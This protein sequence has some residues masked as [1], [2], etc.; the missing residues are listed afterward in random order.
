MASQIPA[1]RLLFSS[2]S[3]LKLTT[4]KA[5]DPSLLGIWVGSPPLNVTYF[6]TKCNKVESVSKLGR[7]RHLICQVT[8]FFIHIKRQKLRKNA[9]TWIYY[10]LFHLSR[11]GGDGLFIQTIYTIQISKW[12]VNVDVLLQFYRVKNQQY[13][14]HGVFE[15]KQEISKIFVD[16]LSTRRMKNTVRQA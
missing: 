15:I 10:S 11:R 7:Y 13:M 4:K 14:I 16:Q 12:Q 1:P 5:W 6:F 3:L 2:N 8:I 9:I